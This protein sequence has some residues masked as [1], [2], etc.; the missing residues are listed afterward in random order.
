MFENQVNRI[1][2][3]QYIICAT[4]NSEIYEPLFNETFEET[5]RKK[6]TI[7]FKTYF[8]LSFTLN[9]FS[10]SFSSSR[11]SFTL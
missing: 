4:N 9:F 1:K 10:L 5:P 2:R 6:Q 3:L 8:I 11:E 7:I